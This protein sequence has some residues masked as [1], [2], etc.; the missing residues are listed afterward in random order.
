MKVCVA[1]KMFNVCSYYNVVLYFTTFA[2]TTRDCLEVFENAKKSRWHHWNADNFKMLCTNG[3]LRRNTS[4]SMHEKLRI[5]TP[6]FLIRCLICNSVTIFHVVRRRWSL[7]RT[8]RWTGRRKCSVLIQSIIFRSRSRLRRSVQRIFHQWNAA[9][10]T[11]K[12]RAINGRLCFGRLAV[13]RRRRIALWIGHTDTVHR[14]RRR[15]ATVVFLAGTS[16][17]SRYSLTAGWNVSWW[18][19]WFQVMSVLSC[20]ISRFR[21]TLFKT[22]AFSSAT[23]DDTAGKEQR[24]TTVT[25]SSFM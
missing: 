16:D 7:C 5:I 22:V 20:T 25:V 23:K 24:T 8:Q 11:L 6:I 14:N 9:V 2:W 18:T 13:L 19:D 21:C 17:W 15:H 1:A 12:I 3:M 4:M 10:S